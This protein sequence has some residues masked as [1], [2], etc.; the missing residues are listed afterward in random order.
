MPNSPRRAAAVRQIRPKTVTQAAASGSEEQLLVALRD[1]IA[2]AITQGVP[3]RDLSSLSRRLLEVQRELSALEARR[4]QEMP[5]PA[6]QPGG[7]L[8]DDDEP[9]DARL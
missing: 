5:I 1:T 3:A 4:E 7:R 8:P 2:G 6:R 9:W